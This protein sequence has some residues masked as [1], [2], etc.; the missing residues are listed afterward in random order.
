MMTNFAI[1]LLAFAV[2][3]TPAISCSIARPSCEA[4]EGEAACLERIK[5]L[6]AAQEAA[7]VA[8]E[9]KTPQERALIEQAKLLGSHE[10]IFLAKVEKIKLRGKVYPQPEPKQPTRIARKGPVPPPEAPFI[11]FPEYG[12]SYE[13]YLNP[14]RWIKG[15]KVFSPSWQNVGG[16]T[17]CGLSNDGSLASS[18][19]DDEIIIF[20]NRASASKMVK[21]AW[22]SSEFL[23]LYGIDR[24]DLIEPTILTALADSSAS[25]NEPPK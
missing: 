7:R 2:P 15:N 12:E 20:A 1:A 10:F 19:P 16:W 22:V 14:I 5:Q 11:A 13:A 23:S 8:Y 24:Q 18:Y 21:G 25:N 9:K 3:A 17:S 6:D 4:S